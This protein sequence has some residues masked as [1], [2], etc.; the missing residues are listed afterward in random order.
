MGCCTPAHPNDVALDRAPILYTDRSRSRRRLPD[1]KESAY[2]H[3][4]GAHR[5]GSAVTTPRSGY[6]RGKTNTDANGEEPFRLVSIEPT[7]APD[8]GTGRDWFVYRIAQGANLITGYRQGDLRATTAEVE[9]I[10][11]GLNE[12]R[13]GSKGRPGPKPK[14]SAAAA[15]PATPPDTDGGDS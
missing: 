6:G 3:T 1:E 5:V 2:G 9:R 4:F 13:V 12:R 15:A 8:G 11:A 7:R 10:V 14:T